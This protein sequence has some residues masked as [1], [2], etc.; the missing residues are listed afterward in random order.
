VIIDNGEK[1]IWNVVDI[2][3]ETG[4]KV[5]CHGTCEKYIKERT[6]YNQEKNRI[7]NEKVRNNVMVSYITDPVRSV[8]R[9]KLR[10]KK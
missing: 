1:T 8:K 6:E 9:K 2:A 7:F 5:G 3:S 4:R 10:R